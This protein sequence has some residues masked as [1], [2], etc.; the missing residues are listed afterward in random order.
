MQMRPLWKFIVILIIC[1]PLSSLTQDEP[2]FE[3]TFDDD[4]IPETLKIQ[5]GTYEV[6]DGSLSYAVKNGGFLVIPGGV[7]WTD[8]AIETRLQI[9]AG[10]VWLQARTGGDLCSGY[11]LTINRD[12][13]FYDLS[14]SDRDCNFTVLDLI[15]GAGISADWLLARIEVQGDQIR[16]Y[17]N[18]E[19]VFSVTDSQYTI[20]YPIINVFPT[21]DDEA[22]VKFDS[23]RVFDL[24][25]SEPEVEV[26][27]EAESTENPIV[28]ET[29][30][31]EVTAEAESTENPIVEE[32]PEVEIT[33]E[34]IVLELPTVDEIPL[35]D[36]PVRM[37]ETLQGLDLIPRGEGQLYTQD[38]LSISRIGAWFDPLFGE[39]TAQH[40]VMSGTI[41]FLPYSE[42]EL[43]LL[44]AR[45]S[46]DEIGVAQAYLDVGLNSRNEVFVGESA[47]N[48][49]YSQAT[50]DG[51]LTDLKG[52]FLFI[53]YENRLSV[54]VDGQAVFQNIEVT[55]RRGSL[56]ISA[57]ES[58]SY[59][60]CHISD[61]WAYT[62]ED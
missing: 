46:R 54:Y 50:Q 33:A 22:Q 37:I 56:G 35:D 55:P 6:L 39:A 51:F 31:I 47:D 40:V 43:C 38:T 34:A 58:T 15:E 45:I 4:T 24:S 27:A 12:K 61:I 62:F 21:A 44:S 7:A 10:S 1:L 60:V 11:Y 14:V 53:A 57:I 28:E 26:T 19:A 16:A 25:I 8:Y 52:N 3:A 23:I 32:T 9:Q 41:D 42:A 18:D 59:S 20:G 2:L 30:E 49:H 36:D 13:D 17:I 5:F 48:G 29:P